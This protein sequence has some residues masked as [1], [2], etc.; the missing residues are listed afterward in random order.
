MQIKL[1]E[2]LLVEKCINNIVQSYQYDKQDINALIDLKLDFISFLQSNEPEEVEYGLQYLK[3]SYNDIYLLLGSIV[4]EYQVNKMSGELYCKPISEDSKSF[5]EPV[6]PV[7][8]NKNWIPMV[9]E[10]DNAEE[11]QD[12]QSFWSKLLNCFKS[13]D[14]K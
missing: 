14:D 11:P 8:E 2:K 5:V 10:Y 3:D 13:K 9:S 4:L 6:V 7:H 12:K 1:R